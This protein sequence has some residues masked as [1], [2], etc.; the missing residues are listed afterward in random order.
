VYERATEDGNRAFHGIRYLARLGD[1]LTNWAICEPAAI[2]LLGAEELSR[3]DPDL[4]AAIELFG[5]VLS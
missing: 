2:D 4:A 1:D 3:D 5:L